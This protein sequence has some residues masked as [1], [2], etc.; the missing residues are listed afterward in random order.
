MTNFI[1]AFQGLFDSCGRS[2]VFAMKTIRFHLLL[3]RHTAQRSLHAWIRSIT[4]TET[5]EEAAQWLMAREV[6]FLMKPVIVEVGTTT[7]SQAGPG[8]TALT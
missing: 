7:P 5:R 8:S 1:A 3:L 2:A 6:T 4:W